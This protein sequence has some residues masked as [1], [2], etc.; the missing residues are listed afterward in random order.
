[1]RLSAL[2]KGLNAAWLGELATKDSRRNNIVVQRHGSKAQFHAPRESARSIES[3]C[4]SPSVT[5][6]PDSRQFSSSSD[7][8]RNPC[9]SVTAPIRFAATSRPARGRPSLPVRRPQGKGSHGLLIAGNRAAAFKRAEFSK[10][11]LHSMLM[12]PGTEKEGFWSCD[13]QIRVRLPA[14]KARNSWFPS[15][16]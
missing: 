2:N 4:T 14:T 10:S 5:L 6:H 9:R 7:W 12:N 11:M 16:A 1:M 8:T 13:A 15:R 3:C